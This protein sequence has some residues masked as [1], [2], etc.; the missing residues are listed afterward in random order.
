MAG[1][2]AAAGAATKSSSLSGFQQG[3]AWGS[4]ISAVGS[5]YTSYQSSRS[6]SELAAIQERIAEINR[7]RAVIQ[8]QS[9][10]AASNRNI[11][12]ITQQYGQLKSKQK[13]AMAANGIALGYGSAKEVIATTDL[14]KQQDRNTAYANGL[15]AAM[16][17]MSKATAQYQA[18]V[19]AAASKSN[20][21]M[22]TTDSLL[23]G[24]QKVAGYYAN[25]SASNEGSA[26][27]DAAG[28]TDTTYANSGTGGGDQYSLQWIY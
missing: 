18:G 20:T 15:N 13:T 12:N 9:A 24:I 3:M 16:G 10:L 1:E 7:K 27:A 8:A 28:A 2:T 23:T 21:A 22:V 11:A 14:Y 6:A 5:I 17:Y 4:V 25:A 26:A 19:A